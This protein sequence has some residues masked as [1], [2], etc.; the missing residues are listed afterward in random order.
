MG[1]HLYNILFAHEEIRDAFNDTYKEF[2]EKKGDDPGL[3]LR[4]KLFFDKEAEDLSK[5]PWE[6]LYMPSIPGRE[7]RSGNF[8]VS[9]QIDLI[10][11]RFIQPSDTMK[12]LEIHKEE[13]KILIVTAQPDKW[14]S[15]DL[16]AIKIMEDTLSPKSDEKRIQ[17]KVRNDLTLETLR[18][19]VEKVQPHILHFIGHGKDGKIVLIRDENDLAYN[20]D[21]GGKQAHLVENE[22]LKGLFQKHK[23]RLIFLQACQGATS[24]FARTS[25]SVMSFNNAA[26]VLVDADIPAVVAMQYSIANEDARIFTQTVYEQLSQGK[27]VDE[28]VKEGRISLGKRPPSWGHPRFGTPIVYLQSEK[29][30]IEFSDEEQEGIKQ[31]RCPFFAKCKRK[32]YP[33][34]EFCSCSFRRRVGQESKS[35]EPGTGA[36]S[37]KDMPDLSQSYAGEARRDEVKQEDKQSPID[38]RTNQPTRL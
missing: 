25:D 29:A 33:D 30:I 8:L 34:Q 31:I 26:R 36:V 20:I 15:I 10:L 38:I 6:F 27:D 14:G 37:P 9:E 2:L 22:E 19:E 11:T 24:D 5:L 7:G 28:A 4:L 12:K 21:Q 13:L 23:P 16:D 18:I 1:I 17:V 35:V 3:R 32:I